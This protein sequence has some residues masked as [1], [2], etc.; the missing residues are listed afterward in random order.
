[1]IW[2]TL[3]I[4]FTSVCDT[5]CFFFL[6]WKERAHMKR[7]ASQIFRNRWLAISLEK[8]SVWN[9]S[10][11]VLLYGKC[12]FF[13]HVLLL[14]FSPFD[15]HICCLLYVGGNTCMCFYTWVWVGG[16]PQPAAQLYRWIGFSECCDTLLGSI[17]AENSLPS[18]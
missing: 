2:H 12:S 11:F 7:S 9:T 8:L 3:H 13:L 14:G 17:N 15:D 16:E 4:T 6:N 10:I 1:M 18:T 5:I